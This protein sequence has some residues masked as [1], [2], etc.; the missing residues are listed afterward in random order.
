ML[1]DEGREDKINKSRE[2][3]V[4]EHNDLV[5]RQRFLLNRNAGTSLSLEEEKII[6]YLISQIKPNSDALEPLVFDIK[7]F[8]EICGIKTA[9]KTNSYAYLKRSIQKLAGRVMWLEDRQAQTETTVRYIDRAIIKKG[10]WKIEIQLDNMLA[11]YLLN[12]AGN[13][14]Q[15][16]FHNILAMKSKY[17]IALYKLL[18][19]YCYTYK[20]V[21][22]NIEDLKNN[23][24]AAN[25]DNFTMFKRKVIDP[26]LRDINT[27]SDLSVSVR[28]EKTGRAFSH[29]VFDIES[30]EKPRTP[31]QLQEAQRR[32]DNAEKVIDPNQL[33]FSD[34]FGE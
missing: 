5:Q 16:S 17:G 31:E 19:S 29:V 9:D 10:S 27:Y 30:L 11:P 21:R 33:T 26:A 28:Y 12:L 15:F 1:L 6:A 34:L 32:Y 22:F 2:Y 3:L 24:D 13:F 4:V 20:H 18:K 23:L 7:T 25:Y 14:F 8:C